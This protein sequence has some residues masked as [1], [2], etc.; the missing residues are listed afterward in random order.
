MQTNVLTDPF[1]FDFEA[2]PSGAPGEPS[3]VIVPAEHPGARQLALA[4]AKVFPEAPDLF[5]VDGAAGLFHFFV[6]LLDGQVR[7]IARLSAPALLAGNP[8][9]APFFLSDM[10]DSDPSLTMPDVQEYYESQGQDVYRS[11]SVETQFRLGEH[12]TPIRSADLLYLALFQIVESGRGSG[13]FA[14]LNAR[15]ISSFK[16]VGLAW[17]PFAG[18]V[19]L[20]TPTVTNDSRGFDPD[21]HPVFV[22]REENR[23][24]VLGLAAFTP[25][26]TLV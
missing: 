7:H 16:R 19:D 17:H 25:P 8:G 11:V 15:A 24:V 4:E 22:P 5:R 18:R 10:V 6:L 1:P 2:P 9:R 13:A 26:L 12:L 21:Y 23:D 3:V 20:R 14:H